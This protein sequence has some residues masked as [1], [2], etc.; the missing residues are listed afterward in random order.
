LDPLAK[1][2]FFV[3]DP[4]RLNVE[5]A[6][7][8][9]VKLKHH[10]EADLGYREIETRSVFFI[11]RNDLPKIN[12]LMRLKDLYNVKI[13]ELSDDGII[14]RFAGREM[15]EGI[16]KVQWTTDQ[17]IDV[18]VLVPDLLYRGNSLNENSLTTA[19]GYGE[20]ACRNLEVGDHIQFERFGFCRID[21]KTQNSVIACFSHK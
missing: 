16:T 3:K 12:D 19:K 6:P 10:P 5:D 8:L 21:Q 18:E 11:S 7:R 15:Q 20:A 2:Y 13:T 4:V 9:S 1:R 17:H 14:G